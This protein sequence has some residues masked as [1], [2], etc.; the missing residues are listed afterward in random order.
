MSER[1]CYRRQSHNP[2]LRHKRRFALFPDAGK[3]TGALAL[4]WLIAETG[5]S[6]RRWIEVHS[7]RNLIR[8]L[9]RAVPVG[10][11]RTT[12]CS[13]PGC[14]TRYTGYGDVTASVYSSVEFDRHWPVHLWVHPPQWAL[15]QMRAAVIVRFRSPGR[16]IPD[17][18]SSGSAHW[19]SG[20]LQRRTGEPAM[21]EPC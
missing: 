21:G 8:A 6:R 17:K 13:M 10:T 19:V 15:S 4:R 7:T 12:A 20:S 14:R 1:S 2:L 18:S 3:L 9:T 16:F 11:V 5:C